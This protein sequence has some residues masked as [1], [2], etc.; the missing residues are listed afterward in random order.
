MRKRYLFVIP[1]LIIIALFWIPG[2]TALGQTQALPP[3]NLFEET[4]YTAGIF[5]RHEGNEK[6]AGQAWGDYD[7]DGW[8]DL[9]ITDT[10]GPN[11]LFRNNGDGTFSRSPVSDQVALPKHESGG[12][13]F[14]DFDNDGWKDLYVVNWGENI[15]FRNIKG[16]RFENVTQFAGVGN[17][18]NGLT[19]SWADYDNDGWLD[20]YVAN[21]SCYPRCGR[22]ATGDLD[23]LYRNNS[24]GTFTNVTH[25]LGSKVRGAGFVAGFID[26]DNDGDQDI[27]LINDEFILD[28]GNVLWRNDGS[29]CA[30][31]CFTEISAEAN[32]NQRVMGMGLATSDYDRDGDFDMFFTNAGPLTLLQNDG[33]GTFTEAES[34]AGIKSPETVAFGT[35]FFDYDND[36]WQDLYVAQIMNMEMD[37]IPANPLFRNNGDGTFTRVTAHVGA[38]DPNGSIGVATAD[39]DNDGWLDLVVGNYRDGYRLYRNTGGDHHWLRLRLQGAGPVNRD[40]VGTRVEV[41]MA[42]GDVQSGWVQN[43]AS[44]GSGNDL[45][46]H[47]GLGGELRAAQV[48]VRWPD[49]HTQTF[50]NVP[51]DREIT[52]VYPLD[53]SAEAAQIAVLYPPARAETGRAALPF[54]IGITLVLG[55]A[56]LLINGIPTPSPAFL[57]TSGAVVASIV[58]LS[59]IGLL[60][61]VQP[62]QAPTDPPMNGLQDMLAFHDIQPLGPVPA[63]SKAKI[64]LGEALFWDPILSGNEDI[65][66][67]TCHHSALSTGDELPLSIGTGGEDLGPAR[68]I[69][70]GREL[71]P[72]NAPAVFNLGH[73]EWTVMFWDG[74]VREV[75]PGVFD[76]P[77]AGRLPTGL[78]SALAAQAMFPV[79]SRDEMRGNRGDMT[80]HGAL[81]EVTNIK[82]YEVDVQWEA[83]MERLMT[84]PTYE[85]MFRAAYPG[86][87]TFEFEHAANAMAAYQAHTFSF[88]DSPFDRFL[89]GDETALSSDAKA[90]AELFYGKANCVQCH[91]TSLLTDQ[92]F[93]NLAVPQ[94]GP[95]KAPEEPFDSGRFRETGD[96]EDRFAFR[97][98]PLR[99]V[100]LTAPYMHNGT[101]ATLEDVLRHHI[102]PAQSLAN[103]APTHLASSVTITNDPATQERLLSA[104]GFEPKP[105]PN[106]NETEIAQILAFLDALTSP[107]A[108]DLTHTIPNAVP[109][110]LSVGGQ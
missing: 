88:F 19:A 36:G 104:P 13:N 10:D 76:S 26:I 73:P 83:L 46:L 106:L 75:L 63:A 57:K 78:D 34:F 90:G 79:T 93:H 89:A 74:R 84:I 11:T 92:D 91:S 105:V 37:S 5:T 99:N 16:E 56:A 103:Y 33:S 2:N 80:I 15:L 55:G 65:A 7:N 110:G 54:L 22:Q 43:G 71:V 108:L 101:Y 27:Y 14:V 95:G 72:R 66:C 1:I 3:L 97:T 51:G 4:T 102:D 38:A 60:L 50:R 86:V 87:E 53:E 23:V 17:P 107:S 61:P 82:D 58:I 69:G 70:E 98:P 9:Y 47:F 52:L 77:A 18:D 81:N 67:A 68:M 109:S 8:Q 35:V 28:I 40:A 30:G 29:G 59:A 48:T 85:A 12:A 6:K 39:Y 21:W 24:D 25:L 100:T 96:E 45:A 62:A 44:M 42:N 64:R 20:V 49:G 94:I 41:T 31:W 32:A